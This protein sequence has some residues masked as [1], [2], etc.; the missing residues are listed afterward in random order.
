MTN[1]S[2]RSLNR[3][4]FM[5]ATLA[6]TAMTK[7]A[8]VSVAQNA[9]PDSGEWSFTDDKGITVT[10]PA[11]PERLVVD[12]NAAGPLWDFGIRPDALFGWSVMADG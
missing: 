8:Q 7:L 4:H 2:T 12:L 1:A 9:T 11:A 10:L 6:G 5:A 3:R